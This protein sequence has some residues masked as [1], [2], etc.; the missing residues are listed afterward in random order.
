ME[1]LQQSQSRKST[2]R[3]ERMAT[4]TRQIVLEAP[5]GAAPVGGLWIA[6]LQDGRRRTLEMLARVEPAKVDARAPYHEHT[7]GTLLY[8][9]AIIEADWLYVEIQERE[10]Y[11]EAAI[12]M[13]PYNH[14]DERGNLTHVAGISLGGHLERLE[15]VRAQMIETLLNLSDEDFS[16]QRKIPDSV[17]ST[18]WVVHHLMQ[19]E[20]EHRGEMGQ[21]LDVLETVGAG[22]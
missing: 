8:H 10:T 6:A 9:I 1:R 12:E 16:R 18:A 5:T 20:A 11:P 19:H 21:L 13:F 17:V 4:E 3:A 22:E 14:R 15:W 2:E 7:I